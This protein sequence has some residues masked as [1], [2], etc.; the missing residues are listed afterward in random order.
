MHEHF[1]STLGHNELQGTFCPQ[2]QYVCLGP[3]TPPTVYGTWAYLG[4]KFRPASAG[5]LRVLEGSQAGGVCRGAS[6]GFPKWGKE[7][8]THF[9]VLGFCVSPDVFLF[10]FHNFSWKRASASVGTTL[11]MPEGSRAEGAPTLPIGERGGR[12]PWRHP[13]PIVIP[14]VIPR[15]VASSRRFTPFTSPCL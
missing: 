3:A 2:R 1:S 7:A 12:M 4:P 15:A 6:L 14:S 10:F 13:S 5:T 11:R 9:S 8:G